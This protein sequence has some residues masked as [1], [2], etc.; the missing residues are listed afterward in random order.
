MNALCHHTVAS[1]SR[2]TASTYDDVDLNRFCR[3][4]LQRALSIN[5]GQLLD[6]RI[7][8]ALS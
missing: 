5:L 8:P 1:E 7:S 3:G 4:N 6:L 2:V